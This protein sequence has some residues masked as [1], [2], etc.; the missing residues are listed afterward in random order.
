MSSR[1]ADCR[2]CVLDSVR[3]VV[4][5]EDAC[6]SCSVVPFATSGL[7]AM[8]LIFVALQFFQ[9]AESEVLFRREAGLFFRRC[10]SDRPGSKCEL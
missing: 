8:G 2:L 9:M 4:A 3:D 10:S 7:V 5:G 6:R 1:R